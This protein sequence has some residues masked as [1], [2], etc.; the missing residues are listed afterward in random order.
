MILDFFQRGEIRVGGNII[1][2]NLVSA[3]ELRKPL[4]N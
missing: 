4:G 2:V 3:G 1:G